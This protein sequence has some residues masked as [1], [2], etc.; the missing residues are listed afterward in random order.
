MVREWGGELAYGKKSRG[1][2][3]ARTRPGAREAVPREE[4][5][6]SLKR[7]AREVRSAVELVKGDR[8]GPVE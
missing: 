3:F 8:T 5:N 2:G 6:R 1:C 7:K 4:K